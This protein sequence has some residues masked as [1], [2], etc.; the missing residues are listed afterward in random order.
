MVDIVLASLMEAIKIQNDLVTGNADIQDV[1]ESSKR[2]I[3][4]INELID[5][6]INTNID[7]RRKAKLALASSTK[8]LAALNSAPPPLEEIDLDDVEY[9]REWFKEYKHWYDN[10]R[11]LQL[12]NPVS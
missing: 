8:A 9:V 10:K 2:F 4:A 6:R 1:K 12:N 11:N 3:K 7:E 5:D